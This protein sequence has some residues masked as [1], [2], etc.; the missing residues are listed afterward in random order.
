MNDL[1]LRE[2]QCLVQG[3]T[4]SKW[5]IW[6]LSPPMSDSQVHACN[7]YS[8][9]LTP[10][11][12]H[13]TLT[14]SV[15]HNCPNHLWGTKKPRPLGVIWVPITLQPTASTSRIPP[16]KAKA[17]IQGVASPESTAPSPSYFCSSHSCKG[18]HFLDLEH[19]L[20]GFLITSDLAFNYWEMTADLHSNIYPAN[21]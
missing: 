18:Q 8:T 10:H 1:R 19:A 9:R 6:E 2:D 11:S 21:C 12:N 3:N 17:G 16:F 20:E 5:L 13:Q 14:K 7:H 15:S 4:D